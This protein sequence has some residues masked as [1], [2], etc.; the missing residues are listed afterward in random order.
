M[1]K[2]SAIVMCLGMALIF[3]TA[4]ASDLEMI[5]GLQITTRLLIGLVLMAGGFFKGRLWE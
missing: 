3:G 5:T 4:G 1:K 2:L